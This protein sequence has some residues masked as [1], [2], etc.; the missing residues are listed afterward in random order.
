ML[1]ATLIEAI[2]TINPEQPI[3]LQTGNF[4]EHIDVVT[5]NYPDIPYL[6]KPYSMQRLL[7]VVKIVAMIA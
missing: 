3:I 2:R 5:R 6:Q 7:E 4:G 1:G